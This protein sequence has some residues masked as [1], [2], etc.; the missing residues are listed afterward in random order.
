MY[1][2]SLTIRSGNTKITLLHC[3]QKLQNH[4]IKNN[5]TYVMN[6][7]KQAKSFSFN[8]SLNVNVNILY[9]SSGTALL[10]KY[11]IKQYNNQCLME[12]TKYM[13]PFTYIQGVIF[14]SAFLTSNI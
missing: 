2:K 8:K 9:N 4:I 10:Y 5:I 3:K 12:M 11:N 1:G 7:I 6:I 13:Y 14:F